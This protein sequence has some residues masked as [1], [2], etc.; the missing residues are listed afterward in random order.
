MRIAI[1][2]NVVAYAEGIGDIVRRDTTLHV[3]D[4]LPPGTVMLPV[5]VLGELFRVL[6][7]KAKL[8]PDNARTI[9][10]QWADSFDVADS[11]WAAFQAAFD[12]TV[13]HGLGIW[14]ALILA[15]AA[16][17]RCRLLLTEDLHHGFT[18]RGVTV[19]NP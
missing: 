19:V 7:G 4:R 16:E 1:D 6:T 5:Q 18:W 2:T 15:V 14:D 9:V 11:T 12:L 3:I 8:P 13:D 10:Q 17:N